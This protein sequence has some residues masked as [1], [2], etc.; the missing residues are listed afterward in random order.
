MDTQEYAMKLLLALL[1]LLVAGCGAFP[2]LEQTVV[3]TTI[4]HNEGGR[5]GQPE[6]VVIRDAESWEALHKS[7][8]A[9]TEAAPLPKVDFSKNMVVGIFLGSKKTGG[10][11]VKITRIQENETALEVLYTES[12]PKGL[13]AQVTSYPYHLV[14]VKSTNKTVVFTKN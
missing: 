14:S 1:A 12:T 3:F 8:Y 10:Y 9:H 7:M 2:F 13:A 5:H 4:E 6:Q 11:D